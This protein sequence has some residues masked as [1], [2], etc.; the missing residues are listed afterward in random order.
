[1][2]TLNDMVMADTQAFAIMSQMTNMQMAKSIMLN[3]GS[4]PV[5]MKNKDEEEKE[6]DTG[7]CMKLPGEHDHEYKERLTCLMEEAARN[8]DYE[9]AAKYQKVLRNLNF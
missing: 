5:F 8:C 4:F 6:D 2:D 9:A 3:N 7:V 1:M